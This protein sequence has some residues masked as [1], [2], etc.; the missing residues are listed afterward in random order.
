[1]GHLS[2]RLVKRGLVGCGEIIGYLGDFIDNENGGWSRH[3]HLQLLRELTDNS[4]IP[5]GYGLKGEINKLRNNYPDP[6]I[7]FKGWELQ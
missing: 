4:S 5:N 7:Y 2:S 1:M 3:L 6:T